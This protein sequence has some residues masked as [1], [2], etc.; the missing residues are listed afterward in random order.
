MLNYISFSVS[1]LIAAVAAYFS[2]VGL[3]TI[4]N[5]AFWSVVIMASVLEVGK[6][7]TATWL[8]VYWDEVKL[9]Y[10][11]Y[12]VCAVVVLMLI[13]SMGIFG[14][15]SR[16]HF[17]QLTEKS[18][19]DLRIENT[20]LKISSENEKLEDVNFELKS[21]NDA[22]QKYTDLGYVSK[23]LEQR[24]IQRDQK[25]QLLEEKNAISQKILI[26][27]QEQMVYIKQIISFEAEIGP[28]KYVGQLIFGVSKDAVTKAVTLVILFLTFAFDPLAVILLIVSANK[29]IGKKLKPKLIVKSDQ[30]YNMD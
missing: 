3:G 29:I 6:L 17:D 30:V 28:V 2:I 11:A 7:V 25:E 4:F 22:L 19:I 15:L 20:E 21:L 18:D 12:L 14:Y 1:I 10:R 27:K 9:A 13:T 5:G 8:H 16:A 23:G 24:K 26:Y